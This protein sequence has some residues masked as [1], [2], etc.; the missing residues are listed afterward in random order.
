MLPECPGLGPHRGLR[1]QCRL[2][3]SCWFSPPF[4][5]QFASLRHTHIV[6]LLLLSHLSPTYL[7]FLA[8]LCPAHAS[9]RWVGVIWMPSIPSECSPIQ[10]I[11]S[12][13]NSTLLLSH[14]TSRT[15]AWTNLDALFL[16]ASCHRARECSIRVL[17]SVFYTCYWRK[18]AS[19]VSPSCE[20]HE[21]Q[22]MIGWQDMPNATVA[23][24][25]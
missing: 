20:P 11:L 6:P 3:T 17:E 22:L 5:L 14:R 16:L 21:L 24:I 8:V 15:Q 23:W 12:I 10:L 7:L 4:C 2:L 13:D 25:L 9:C 18:K 1:W 19:V